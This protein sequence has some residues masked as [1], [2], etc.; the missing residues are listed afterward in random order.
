[1]KMNN[2]EIEEGNVKK[3]GF[4]HLKRKE[5]CGIWHPNEINIPE[6]KGKHLYRVVG[7]KGSFYTDLSSLEK[8][9][10]L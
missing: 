10:I 6:M 8:Y 7:K 4:K 1:M 3:K 2:Y 9:D 5:V